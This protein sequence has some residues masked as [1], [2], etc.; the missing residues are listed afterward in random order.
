VPPNPTDP[1]AAK[2]AREVLSLAALMHPFDPLRLVQGSLKPADLAPEAEERV[3]TLV[4]RDA[5]EVVWRPDGSDAPPRTYWRLNPASRRRE[6][7]RL[8]T[9]RALD[10]LLKRVEPVAGDR[11]S[12]YL[13]RAL[14]GQPVPVDRIPVAERHS[15]N[16]AL[17]FAAD[18]LVGERAEIVRDAAS[19]LR[20]R[21]AR[22]AEEERVRALLP[23][24]LYGR[25]R[26][27]RTFDAFVRS[28]LV[29]AALPEPSASHPGIRPYLL[30]GSPGSG[31]SA[32]VV[33]LVRRRRR[34][35]FS[36]PPVALLDFDRP[37]LA[38]GSSFDWMVEVTRQL[39]FAHPDLDRAMRE[40]RA[41]VRRQMQKLP[42]PVTSLLA[43]TGMLKE[44]LEPILG[45]SAHAG[46][47]LLIVLD[48]FEEV[49]AR[50]GLQHSVASDGTGATL[51]ERLLEWIASL[52]ALRFEGT[53]IFPT[54][55]AIA[56][57]RDLPSN[58]RA[59]LGHW[60]C[61]HD[62]LGPLDTRAAIAFLRSRDAHRRFDEARAAR[63][64]EAV[65]GHPL[66]LVLLERYARG[67]GD[68]ELDATI[69]DQ[70][71]TAV[72]GGEEA[73]RSL[74]ARLVGRLY[75]DRTT[76]AGITAQMLEAAASPGL[77]LRE[78][79]APL[80]CEVVAPTCGIGPI[81]QA[82]AAVLLGLLADQG[83]LLEPV[84][85][86]DEPT[87]RHRSNVRRLMLPMM[88][89]DRAEPGRRT[90]ILALRR[91]AI[92]WFDARASEAAARA[93]VAYHRA[94]LDELTPWAA[95][96][97]L[98]R[99]VAH[100]AG[101]DLFEMPT[102][103][104]AILRY[105]LLGPLRLSPS[106]MS[107]L[108]P[109]LQRDTDLQQRAFA[110]AQGRQRAASE[111]AAASVAA[112]APASGPTPRPSP[113]SSML[114]LLDDPWLRGFVEDSFVAGDFTQAASV[115]WRKLLEVDEWPD[116]SRPFWITDKSEAGPSSHWIWQSSLA[117]LALGDRAGAA[118][119]AAGIINFVAAVASRIREDANP[120]AIGVFLLAAATVA[121]G[122]RPM[123]SQPIEHVSSRV[124]ERLG[125]VE[126]T[127]QMRLLALIRRWAPGPAASSG[128]I[129]HVGISAYQLR[130]FSPAFLQILKQA[131]AGL[132]G[133]GGM[134]KALRQRLSTLLEQGKVGILHCAETQDLG[135]RMDVAISAAWLSWAGPSQASRGLLTDLHA[136]LL[137][138]VM[139]TDRLTPAAV[140]AAFTA[141]ERRAPFWPADLSRAAANTGDRDKRV[142][143]FARGLF[144]VDQCGL[145][146]RFAA[147]LAELLP[148]DRHLASIAKLIKTYE[149][150]LYE[151]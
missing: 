116:L 10:P 141:A 131:E 135:P 14:G 148:Q 119:D 64:V 108:P 17:S 81:T 138:A 30:T 125:Y 32:F 137:R 120:T 110:R 124:V 136:V 45:R 92:A 35:D 66:T 37:N 102:A 147:D 43:G 91:A 139:E 6:L 29:P 18:A 54:V 63:A 109:D 1:D 98:C 38:L 65:G 113:R 111:M 48:T 46:S 15:A 78:L 129:S 146:D 23:G 82:T 39:G 11:F 47:D 2:I 114:S 68:D 50:S 31:K 44:Q 80:L 70:T 49:I 71:M 142:S 75:V 150:L 104:R 117:L 67:V 20:D 52:A 126:T 149:S 143:V 130:V 73:A 25:A 26:E 33:D 83:W 69:R 53:A 93:E 3:L 62:K 55:R 103:A 36:G 13:R 118:V 95:D 89:D 8:V 40:V 133:R 151:D 34:R 5:G 27:R 140:D 87:Y 60:F 59:V 101:D 9:E 145:L 105:H 123:V 88:I 100:I 85:D 121:T 4:A 77:V 21:L 74:Y 112:S 127:F 122:R 134:P 132:S 22:Q 106:E 51:V 28:G 56:A 79:T 24:R 94:F 57:G 58:D 12:H 84:P 128:R 72:M 97:A 41:T 107:A 61:A 96:A 16:A 86:R 144:F 90:Q 42:D 115:G 7:A 19:V 76:G 99:M